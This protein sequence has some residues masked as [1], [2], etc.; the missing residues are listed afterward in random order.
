GVLVAVVGR[1]CICAIAAASFAISAFFL[2]RLV[3]PA[4]PAAEHK[5]FLGDLA[6]GWR[7]GVSRRWLV[8]STAAFAFGNLAFAAF[9]VLGPLVVERDLG[10]APAWGLL[11]SAFGL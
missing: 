9:F 8:G 10:G 11:M 7:E 4:A 1:G 2:L 5:S 6:D 3:I